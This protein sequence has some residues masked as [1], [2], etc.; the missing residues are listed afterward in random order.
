MN[1][2]LFAKERKHLFWYIKDPEQLSEASIIEHVLNYGDWNDFKQLISIL[3]IEKVAEIFREKAEK[4]RCN[5]RPKI[6]HYFTR[7]FN[8]YAPR[9]IK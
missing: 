5:Y 4:P 2:G 6:K 8:E 1:I 3:G 7:Y 9:N